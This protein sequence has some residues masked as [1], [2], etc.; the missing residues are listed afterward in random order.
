MAIADDEM[1]SQSINH[2]TH[3]A[4]INIKNASISDP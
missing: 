1:I 4:M 3:T 2:V